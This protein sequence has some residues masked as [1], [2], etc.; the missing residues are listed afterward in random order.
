MFYAANANFFESEDEKD[1]V[2]ELVSDKTY[3]EIH[4][5]FEKDNN[6][7]NI[8][9]I[10]HNVDKFGYSKDDLDALIGD[11]RKLFNADGNADTLEKN[12]LRALKHLLV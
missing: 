3:K 10:L 12:M 4:R 1:M 5:E 6:Y 7:Q 8:Q 2:H 9:K 11:I